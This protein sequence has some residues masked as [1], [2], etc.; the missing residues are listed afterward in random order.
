MRNE[1]IAV[2]I[3]VGVLAAGCSSRHLSP[4]VGDQ[5]TESDVQAVA[6]TNTGDLA[7][8][9]SREVVIYD[10]GLTQIRAR[11]AYP[12]V[13]DGAYVLASDLSADGHVAALAWSTVPFTYYETYDSVT[14]PAGSPPTTVVAFRVPGGEV[15]SQLTY[16]GLQRGPIDT[17]TALQMP[18]IRLSP[19]GDLLTV[20]GFD[21]S[22]TGDV[23]EVHDVV[24]GAVR[25]ST[26]RFRDLTFSPDGALAYIFDWVDSTTMGLVAVD[27]H[28]G[29]VVRTVGT[30]G[31]G[32]TVAASRDGRWLLGVSGP[33]IPDDVWITYGLWDLTTG[34]YQTMFGE[35]PDRGAGEPAALSPDGQRWATFCR[36]W[37]Q[38]GPIR[39]EMHLWTKDGT[40]LLD[41]PTNVGSH[42]A[43]SPDGTE[44]AI[45]PVGL[46]SGAAG[47]SIFRASDGARIADRAVSATS[48]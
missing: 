30:D 5:V 20:D 23:F 12:G 15:L 48:P 16:A 40:L 24:G 34:T 25:W 22:P 33:E 14:L 17:P 36:N 9:T 44:L 46:P 38:E 45:G 18:A 13:P 43:F 29:D 4:D 11:V 35:M 27:A 41:L 21:G 2:R 19:P 39:S 26:R 8:F 37:S 3:V 32:Q 42:P 31:A 7:A 28:T 1:G 6:Y 47:I 10:R